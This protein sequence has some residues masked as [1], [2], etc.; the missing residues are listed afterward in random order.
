MWISVDRRDVHWSGRPRHSNRRDDRHILRYARLKSTASLVAVQT[1][2]APS[3]R[4][5]VF[6]RTITRH[7]AEGHVV[8]L[9]PLR[10]LPTTSTH[11]RLH[12]QW[13]HAR[14]DWTAMEWNQVV[15]SDESR[16]NLSS[17]DN[18]IG[19]LGGREVSSS[20]RSF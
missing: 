3:L 8:S 4:A 6:S 13:C 14:E 12:L 7:M 18:C 16:F 2:A 11:R 9:R 1:Q 10:V 17:D 5:H 19:K 15:F 20:S